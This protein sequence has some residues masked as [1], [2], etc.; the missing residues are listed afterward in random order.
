LFHY[1]RFN[2]GP[3][4]VTS[5]WKAESEWADF[6]DYGRS[7]YRFYDAA[8]RK[9][10]E[11]YRS[12]GRPWYAIESFRAPPEPARKLQRRWLG[13]SLAQRAS[14]RGQQYIILAGIRTDTG[15]YRPLGY[16]WFDQVELAQQFRDIAIFRVLPPAPP[17]GSAPAPGAALAG[18][19]DA[20]G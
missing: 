13:K 6:F 12:Q 10:Y 18:K 8:G 20:G 17:S 4:L 3:R 16:S 7:D 9:A 14:G 1:G 19:D 15:D 5:D 2:H 11:D